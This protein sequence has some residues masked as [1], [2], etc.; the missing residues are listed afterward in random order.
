MLDV[1]ILSTILL[2]IVMAMVELTKKTVNIKKNYIPLLAVILAIVVSSL[3]YPFT[4]LN[5]IMRV[6]AGA[7]AGLAS[8]GLFEITKYRDGFTKGDK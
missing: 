6:W 5:L 2:P 1:L 4:E 8:T 3:A 7:F